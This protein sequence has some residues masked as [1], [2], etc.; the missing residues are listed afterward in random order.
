M[1]IIDRT[2]RTI[3]CNGCGKAVTFEQTNKKAAEKVIVD[4]PWLRT[5][6]FVQAAGRNYVSQKPNLQTIN[7]FPR[8]V[9]QIQPR[10]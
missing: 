4:N 8:T 2:F 7:T 10:P 1:S 9:L 6:R 3:T 5:A